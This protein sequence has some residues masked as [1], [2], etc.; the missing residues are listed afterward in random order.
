MTGNL[1][2]KKIF[3]AVAA[4]SCNG[5]IGNKGQ[6][7][8]HLSEDLKFFKKLTYGSP[9]I[10]GRKTY[11]SIGRPLPGRKNI[12]ISSNSNIQGN[13]EIYQSIEELIDVYKDSTESLFII[14]G[15]QIYSALLNWTKEIYLTYI[16]KEY[17]GDTYFPQ[18]DNDFILNSIEFK[19]EE[20]EVRKMIRKPVVA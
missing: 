3:K 1:L 19:T 4:M 5:V 15:S 9:V 14:G 18:I 12:V 17:S 13:I 20:F 16:Y 8:W 10:M 6:L 2:N 11:E 7:P